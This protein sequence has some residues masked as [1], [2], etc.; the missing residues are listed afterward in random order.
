[1]MAKKIN[2]YYSDFILKPFQSDAERII[3]RAGRQIGK[4]YAGVT[5]AS[6]TAMRNK[7]QKIL[8]V[9]TIQKNIKR[10]IK[11]YF[12]PILKDL[13]KTIEYDKQGDILHFSNGSSIFFWFSRAT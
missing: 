12:K 13:W 1:M 10:Y 6:L 11:E 3:V 2:L 8:W 9:D 4:T 7:N 5:K